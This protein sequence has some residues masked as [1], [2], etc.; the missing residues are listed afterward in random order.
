MSTWSRACRRRTWPA[1][2]IA[3]DFMLSHGYIKRDFDVH[4]WAAPEFME[5]AAE[6]LIEEQWKKV[7]LEKLP[8]ASELLASATRLG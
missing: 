8:E 6:E 4:E 5:A 3:K 2:E 1:S 7:T